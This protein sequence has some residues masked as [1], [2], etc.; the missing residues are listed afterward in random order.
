MFLR[1]PPFP[2]AEPMTAPSN[3]GAFGKR[4]KVLSLSVSGRQCDAVTH[5]IWNHMLKVTHRHSEAKPKNL[6]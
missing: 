5:G 6:R 3:K 4:H 1:L 2:V